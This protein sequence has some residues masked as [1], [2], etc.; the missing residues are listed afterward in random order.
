[1]RSVGIRQL[2]QNASAVIRL[3]IEG[4][5]VEV[6][7]RGR[8]VARIVPLNSESVLDQMV[9][10]GLATRPVRD[11]LSL[12]PALPVRGQPL[13]SQVLQEMRAEER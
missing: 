13:L 8:P 4:E 7:Q 5:P 3:V 6:T 1:M 10:E 9:D 2:R 11:I 12:Q